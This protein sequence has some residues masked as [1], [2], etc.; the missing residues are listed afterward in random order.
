[1]ST[2]VEQLTL[3]AQR[4]VAAADVLERVVEGDET[5]SITTVGGRVL[6][7]IERW[8]ANNFNNL[9][10]FITQEADR[11][12]QKANEARSSEINSSASE[13]AASQ[14]ET[15]SST[16]EANSLSYRNKAG[17]WADENEDV[18]VESG[19]YSAKHHALKAAASA[20]A[21]STSES[22]AADSALAASN[23]AAQLDDQISYVNEHDASTNVAPSNPGGGSVMHRISAAGSFG[24]NSYLVGD[25]TIYDK[26]NS[27]WV[28]VAGNG[29][30]IRSDIDQNV[31]VNL[32]FQDNK[33]AR[34]GN[35]ADLRIYH[36]G[37]DSYIENNTNSLILRNSQN[38]GALR[39]QGKNASATLVNLAWFD[40]DGSAIIYNSGTERLRTTSTGIDVTGTVNATQFN[41][42]GV[43]VNNKFVKIGED[44]YYDNLSYVRMTINGT[45]SALYADQLG[46]GPIASFR[47]GSGRTL[48]AWVGNS[49]DLY[50][51]DSLNIHYTNGYSS[52]ISHTTNS[53][54]FTTDGNKSYDFDN[55]IISSNEIYA[56]TDKVVFRDGADVTLSKIQPWLTLKSVTSGYTHFDQSAGITIGENPNTGG[57]GHLVYTGDGKFY[58][59]MG[60]NVLGSSVT[61]EDGTGVIPDHW[62]MRMSYN[63]NDIDFHGEVRAQADVVA[64]YSDERLKNIDTDIKDALG[65][66]S[67]WRT[68]YYTANSDG[69]SLANG[70]QDKREVGVIAQDIYNTVPE[71]TELAPFDTILDKAGKKKSK[72]GKNYL[73]VKYHR[74]TAILAAGIKQLNEQNVELKS[75]YKA[76]SA[77]LDKLEDM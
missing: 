10:T 44:S 31:T 29:K 7:S 65:I 48:K 68:V 52:K 20:S 13:Q 55:T 66:I 30:Y 5:V 67:K 76:L 1:M 73:T 3:A 12:T 25:F 50:T 28:R 23:A 70:E 62:A 59:G 71:A 21:A 27:K 11:A 46:S 16:S 42:A 36:N 63:S 58:I 45:Y 75:M 34:F 15:N 35:N 54:I 4:A 77:R 53:V 6:P 60:K 14:S 37:T 74:L 8:F 51:K 24:G 18:E 57:L 19:K 43:N 41:M 69:V 26:I 17:A 47:Q 56:K 40:P 2:P 33:Q 49:G 38:S 64:Y 9:Q 22:N 72:S 39:L 61:A 32:E